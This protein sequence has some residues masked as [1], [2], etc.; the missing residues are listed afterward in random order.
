MNSENQDLYSSPE[1]SHENTFWEGKKLLKYLC[2]TFLNNVWKP[3][4]YITS[5]YIIEISWKSLICKFN[6]ICMN[7]YK[8]I[9]GIQKK[10]AMWYWKRHSGFKQQQQQ[11]SSRES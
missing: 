2:K 4:F 1:V 6:L 8:Y 7:I 3:K 11:T 5:T 9:L 10:K